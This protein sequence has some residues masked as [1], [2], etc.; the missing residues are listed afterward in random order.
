MAGASGAKRLSRGTGGAA[1]ETAA[2]GVAAYVSSQP[3][4]N[5]PG[6]TPDR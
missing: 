5:S 1:P 4:R 6:G 3:R 2:P